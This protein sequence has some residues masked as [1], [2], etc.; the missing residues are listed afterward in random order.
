M[1]RNK[2]NRGHLE[3]THK[4]ARYVPATNILPMDVSVI[5]PYRINATP[6]GMIGAMSPLA[7]VTAAENATG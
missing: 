1:V 7:A 2:C 5:T 3:Y 6:G 4:D